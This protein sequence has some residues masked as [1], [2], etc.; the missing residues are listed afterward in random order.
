MVY[1]KSVVFP[2]EFKIKNLRTTIEENLDL[3][4]AQKNQLNQLNELD[5]KHTVVVHHTS[6]IQQQCS[7]WHDQFIKKKAFCEGYWNFLYD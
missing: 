5:K 2:I 6:L 3:T 4:E 7:K 1:K